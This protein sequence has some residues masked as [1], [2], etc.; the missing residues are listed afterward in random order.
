MTSLQERFYMLQL[1]L[2]RTCDEVSDLN[3]GGRPFALEEALRHCLMAA[4][5]IAEEAQRSL[6]GRKRARKS[7]APSAAGA[8]AKKAP[9]KLGVGVPNPPVATERPEGVPHAPFP[10]KLSGSG[11]A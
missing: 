1:S 9:R 8:S 6:R 3:Q 2:Q 5:V 4:L 10:G 11:S 7:A